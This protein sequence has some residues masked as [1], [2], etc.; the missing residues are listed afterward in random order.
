MSGIRVLYMYYVLLNYFSKIGK[1]DE[2]TV[3]IKQKSNKF[4]S[5]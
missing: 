5:V 2:Y 3:V 1:K 4:N